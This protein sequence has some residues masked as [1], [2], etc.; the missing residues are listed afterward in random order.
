VN[1]PNGSNMG[2]VDPSG[3][4]D[5]GDWVT[6]GMTFYLV[7][8]S[9]KALAQVTVNL[10]R[11]G[12]PGG[13]PPPIT[14]LIEGD[15]NDWFIQATRN[16]NNVTVLYVDDR[17][18]AIEGSVAFIAA[19]DL[20]ERISFLY[21]RLPNLK[22]IKWDITTMKTLQVWLSSDYDNGN[23]FR[24]GIPRITLGSQNGTMVL[25]PAIDV[26]TNTLGRN[27][28]MTIPLLGDAI[29]TVTTQGSFDQTAVTSLRIEFEAAVP[30]FAVLVDG[31]RFIP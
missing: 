10:T 19:T 5:T 23:G 21:P 29:W 27:I 8:A 20:G 15:I 3:S 25:S 26:M 18:S 7:D 6:D 31:L 14:D 16:G 28:R 24:P 13:D 1:A 12:C 4:T 2:N 22:P 11:A 30:G 9:L 17:Q